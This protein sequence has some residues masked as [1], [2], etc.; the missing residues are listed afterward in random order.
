VFGIIPYTTFPTI[1]IGPLEV[2]T[3][4]LMVG[5]GVLVGAWVAARFVESRTDVT[6]DDVYKL[7]TKLVIAGIIGSRITW[8]LSHWSEID[9]PVDIVAVWQGG[10]QFSGGFIAAVIVGFPTVRRWS[11]PVRWWNLDGYAYGL[12]IGMAIGRIGC[13]SVGEHFGRASS[14][15][16][17]VR[18]DGGSTR[19]PAVIGQTFHNTAIYEMLWLT[20]F[21]AILTWFVVRHR[22]VPGRLMG[23][24]CVVYG[25]IRF[26]TD[27]LRVNDNRFLGMTGA[28]WMCLALVPTG[29][30]ILVR[31]CRV[32]ARDIATPEADVEEEEAH[33]V[34]AADDDAITSQ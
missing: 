12:T 13:I 20:V 17:A 7:A 33:D 9:S 4:G 6:R 15:L 28:Q 18:Y 10:L 21:F 30:W 22:M 19:E 1:S 2:R 24:F 31:V 14:W 26:S 32:T 11:R 23:L 16:L 29:I 34:V 25:V 3:F 27:T 8:V 5:I